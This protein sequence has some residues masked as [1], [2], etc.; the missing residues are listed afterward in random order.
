M[1]RLKMQK[2]QLKQKRET[3]ALVTALVVGV[4]FWMVFWVGPRDR[5]LSDV[6]DCMG[7]NTSV[8]S[9]DRCAAEIHE[10]DLARNTS[11]G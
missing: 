7:E 10:K 1:R 3:L 8:E 4:A 11:Q 9:Y 6:M 5:F 2:Q